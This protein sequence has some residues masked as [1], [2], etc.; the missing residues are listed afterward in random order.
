M[1]STVSYN[2]WKPLQKASM[3]RRATQKTTLQDLEQLWERNRTPI[4][5]GPFPDSWAA[6]P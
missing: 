2:R 3:M 1:Q 4:V 6:I 5:T